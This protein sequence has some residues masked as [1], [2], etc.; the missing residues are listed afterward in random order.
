M[1][2]KT[3]TKHLPP[4]NLCTCGNPKV[5]IYLSMRTDSDILKFVKDDPDE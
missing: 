3:L 1:I 2:E 5:T 4:K